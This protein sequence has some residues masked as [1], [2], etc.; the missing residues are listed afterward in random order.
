MNLPWTC[1]GALPLRVPLL[2]V[3]AL[4]FFVGAGC[5]K[6]D[7]TVAVHGRVSYRGEA[8]NRGSVTF[9]PA[10][11]RP[12]NTPLREGGRYEARLA[13]GDYTVAV[14]V[15]EPLPPGYK[16]GDPI[17]PPKIVLPAE[18]TTIAKSKL[19][20][21]VSQEGSQAIDFELD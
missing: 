15:S 8:L 3:A 21:S 9:V 17:P 6:S 16:E 14:S 2:C 11:G 19:A 1:S 10:K 4:M 20:A 18:Y 12:V 13:P 7:D 5:G